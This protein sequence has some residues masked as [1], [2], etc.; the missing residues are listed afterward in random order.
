MTTPAPCY[1]YG[2]VRASDSPLPAMT[3]VY[4]A[5]VRTMS[6][7][8]VTAVVSTLPATDL[9]A[10]RDD[11]LAHS[12]VLQALIEDH[13]VVPAHFG[14]VYPQG[15]HLDQLPGRQVKSLRKMLDDLSGRVE[16]QVTATYVAEAVTQAIVSADSRLR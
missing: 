8:G 14:S 1:L 9:R 12:E 10:R 11:L 16:V 13:D 15:F 5:P 3:G 2:F 7:N 6:S 4:G